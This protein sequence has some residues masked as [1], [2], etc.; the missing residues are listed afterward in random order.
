LYKNQAT[1]GQDIG[2]HQYIRYAHCIEKFS[3]NELLLLQYIGLEF[4]SLISRKRNAAEPMK[5]LYNGH[6][7]LQVVM[8]ASASSLH[9]YIIA[10]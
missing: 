7:S 8:S 1:T 10:L 9:V 6:S 4:S 2:T 5:L 3:I